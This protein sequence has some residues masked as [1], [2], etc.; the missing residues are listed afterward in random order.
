MLH[1]HAAR[2]IGVLY[3]AW[4]TGL[5]AGH[6]VARHE[7]RLLRN[8]GHARE[9]EVADL[10]IAILVHLVVP[11]PPHSGYT[12]TLAA[13]L[14][15]AVPDAVRYSLVRHTGQSLHSDRMIAHTQHKPKARSRA[16]RRPLVRAGNAT[17][18]QVVGLE[19]AVQH[20]R[21]VEIPAA[22]ERTE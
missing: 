20:V 16:H 15:R 17:H 6:D 7:H 14:A 13:A 21:R 22:S 4:V 18:Q 10:Q 1:A 5:P 8:L 2:C 3:V 9:S 19:V 12:R 11:T